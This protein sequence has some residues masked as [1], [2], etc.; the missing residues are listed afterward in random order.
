MM[1]TL[2]KLTATLFWA[3]WEVSYHSSQHLLVGSFGNLKILAHQ[4]L[5]QSEDPTFQIID[6]KRGWTYWVRVII[7]P[8]VAQVLLWEHGELLA[9]QQ[10]E[11]HT[12]DL[13]EELFSTITA[14]LA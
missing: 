10:K 1:V 11:K 3:G 5:T 12:V 8:H 2:G 13:S 9:E 4:D 14:K 7:S 6:E